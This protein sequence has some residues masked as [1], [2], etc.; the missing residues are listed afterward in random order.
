[1][2]PAKIYYENNKEHYLQYAKDYYA[3]NRDYILKKIKGKYNDLSDEEKN[4]K[5]VHAKNIYHNVSP[6]DKIKNTRISK[7]LS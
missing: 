5:K 2:M 4:I 1:M 7:K 6:E 3:Y